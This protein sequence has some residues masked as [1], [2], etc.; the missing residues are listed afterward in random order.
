MTDASST[1]VKASVFQVCVGMEGRAGN[2]LVVVSVVSALQEAMSVHT[3]QSLPGLFHQSLLS[4]SEAL[5]RDS[6]SPFH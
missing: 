2:F 6:T 1:D 3:A 4:C 5:D